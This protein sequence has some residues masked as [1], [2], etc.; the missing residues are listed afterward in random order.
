MVFLEVMEVTMNKILLLM[1]AVL[2]V[3]AGCKKN[4]P[5]TA[6][7]NTA[8]LPEES[9]SSET[10][11]DERAFGNWA[12][13]REESDDADSLPLRPALNI[14]VSPGTFG[15]GFAYENSDP[16]PE[17]VPVS[18]RPKAPGYR[19]MPG[20]S[21]VENLNQFDD[22]TAEQLAAIEKNGFVVRPS[23]DDQLFWIYE[24]NDY[25][26]IP[27]FVSVDSA[28]QLYHVFY[29]Y[30]LRSVEKEKLYQNAVRLNEAMIA[31]LV[32]MKTGLRNPDVVKQ[33]DLCIGYF[34]A[35]QLA[36]GFE[37][38]ENF[39]EE[40]KEPVGK[41]HELI[42]GAAGL[43]MSPLY[44]EEFYTLYG[45]LLDYSMFKP[46]GHYTRDADLTR[47]FRG[48]MWYGLVPNQFYN[49]RGDRLPPAAIRSMLTTIALSRLPRETG[50]KLWESIYWTTAFFTGTSDDAGP[51]DYA[52]IVEKILGQSPDLETISSRLDLFYE[53][54]E[55]LPLPTI[56]PVQ[57]NPRYARQ[58][59][60]MGQRYL[61]DTEVLQKLTHR[62][63]RPFP[64][65]LDLF[66]V[67]GSARAE[68]L[69]KTY[70]F[71]SYNSQRP[72]REYPL[73]KWPPYGEIFS[74]LKKQYGA[75]PESKWRS[76]MYNGWL[77]VQQ[78][79]IG[80]Y[81][82]GYPLFMRNAAWEDKSLAGALGSWTELKHD[83]ILY[84]KPN[85]SESGGG[86]EP[87]IL[88]SY[89][90]PNPALYNRLL[91]LTTY[92][93]KNLAARGI[94][95][96]NIEKAAIGIEEL[97]KLL[98]DCSLKELNGED[99]TDKERE[100]LRHYGGEIEGL[101]ASLVLGRQGYSWYNI[102]SQTERDMALIADTGTGP[103]GVDYLEQ[104][105]GRAAEIFVVAPSAGKLWLTRGAVFD[106]YE[107]ISGERMN[108]EEWQALLEKGGAP[109]R[110]RWTESFLVPG[111]L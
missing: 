21:N 2:L 60:F 98:L 72:V 101:S 104:A 10:T 19:I 38:P 87:P 49:E 17:Y 88:H 68:E 37:L 77:W 36:F 62:D 35:A 3:S 102:E 86:R 93:R 58:F 7:Q 42:R 32:Q 48:M 85:M 95:P 73:T 23:G 40:L 67:F 43:S 34:G 106:Y 56:V 65:G 108:D 46:R 84:G 81:G 109:A 29:D 69:I 59:L 57:W 24:R 30:S 90:E 66:A 50:I 9:S 52:S 100:W 70:E 107:F 1:A 80:S 75:F 4:G 14:K 44:G 25:Q 97:L 105:V 92:S 103:D 39:P 13:D 79:L 27:L 111:R 11:F 110:P 28:L 16:G 91:W 53:E 6:V 55:K 63:F 54:L 31:A 18:F 71:S 12:S 47:Y 83:T 45:P 99:L 15:T 22:L 51:H 8:S 61:P 5:E 94:L 89:V 78:A 33:L 41:E 64:T 82:D 74:E 20:L 96:E 26:D 76:G